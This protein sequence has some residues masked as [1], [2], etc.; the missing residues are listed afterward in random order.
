MLPRR[1]GFFGKRAAKNPDAI[2]SGFLELLARFELA[3]A[4]RCGV[5]VFASAHAWDEE[6]LVR[7]ETLRECLQSGAFSKI[8]VLDEKSRGRVKRIVSVEEMI[9]KAKA[10][11]I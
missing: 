6:A 3:E 5:R 7:R 1:S 4:C 10:G 9:K 11:S 2:A 8:A